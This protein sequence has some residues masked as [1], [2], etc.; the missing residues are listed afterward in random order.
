MPTTPTYAFPYPGATDP[1]DVPTDIH[2]LASRVEAVLP[3]L[4]AAGVPVGIVDVKGDLIV[5]S[6]A[7]TVARLAAGSNNQVLTADSSQ[8]LGLK[9]AAAAVSDLDYAQITTAATSTA[10]SAAT[11]ATVITSNSVTYDGTAVWLEV[12]CPFV[13]ASTAST[14]VVFDVWDGGTD[15]GQIGQGL[16]GAAGGSGFPFSAK[17][18][19]TPSAGAHTF[20]VRIWLGASATATFNAG[21]GTIG[22]FAPAYLRVTKV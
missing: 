7:D 18:R 13:T 16:T 4:P 14:N 8:T 17:R 3:T 11:A 15:L 12:F 9:W 19:Y 1:A 2:A 21:A 6:A 5:A 20:T 22:T 10:T